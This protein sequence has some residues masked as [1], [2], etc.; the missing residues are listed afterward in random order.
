V[1]EIINKASGKKAPGSVLSQFPDKLDRPPSIVEVVSP[2]EP[3][4][5]GNPRYLKVKSRYST[6]DGRAGLKVDRIPGFSS[7]NWSKRS[8]RGDVRGQEANTSW[9]ANEVWDEK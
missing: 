1:Q 8:R 7:R 3:F 2:D 4:P 5:Q 6:S 9:A